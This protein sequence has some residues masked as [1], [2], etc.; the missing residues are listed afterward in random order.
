M[1]ATVE[2]L[3]VTAVLLVIA[4]VAIR[5]W[6]RHR[7]RQWLDETNAIVQPILAMLSLAQVDGQ[8]VDKVWGRS[9]ALMN[10]RMPVV[11]DITVDAVRAAF[12]SVDASRL[13]LTDVWIRNHQVNID[14]ALMV[15]MSTRGYVAD[16]KR[17]N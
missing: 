3:I 5:F 12:T 6:Q 4:F 15:N 9:L 10:Y 14:V 1:N 17:L 13:Q 8:P 2:L 11:P 16:L 7:E